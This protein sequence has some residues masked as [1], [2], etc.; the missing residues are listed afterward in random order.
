PRRISRPLPS[1]ARPPLRRQRYRSRRLELDAQTEPE[2]VEK[3]FEAAKLRIAALGKHPVEVL[4]VEL[5][6]FGQAREPPLTGARHVTQRE[7]ED[8][9][10]LLRERG[11]QVGDRLR[12]VRQDFV[13]VLPIVPSPC[14][15]PGPCSRA[16][17]PR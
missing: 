13:Q 12:V 10:I 2:G 9:G 15:D 6:L 14:H 3:R 5:R 4:P 11:V 7:K 16:S 17:T 1:T 8:L